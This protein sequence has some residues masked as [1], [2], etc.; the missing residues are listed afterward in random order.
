MKPNNIAFYFRAFI[1]CLVWVLGI[2]TMYAVDPVPVE[3]KWVVDGVDRVGLVYAPTLA[4]T[5]PTPVMFAFHGHGG[6]MQH[7]AR[8]FA[9]HKHWPEAIVVYLQG[10]NTPGKLTDPEGKKPGWQHGAGAEKDRDLK[11]FDVVLTKLKSDYQVDESRIYSTGHS[12][13]GGF[14][15]LLWSQRGDVFA[16]MAP[17]ASIA[18]QE[19]KSL[20]PKPVLHVA[21]TSDPLVKFD[22]QERMMTALRKLNGCDP[23]GQPW[24]KSGDLVGT[25]YRSEKGPPVITLIF[26]GNHKFPQEASALIVKFF[27]EN[28]KSSLP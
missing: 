15:Y 21:G 28:K 22:W 2:S 17:S 7:A 12:N 25:I 8:T 20:K 1:S 23:K 24:D 18:N 5:S 26:P 19:L 3:K 13:G 6:T 10:L 27:K 4:T 16:A 14:T 9:Y 11:F